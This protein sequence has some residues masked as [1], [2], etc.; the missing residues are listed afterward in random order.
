MKHI[1]S[2]PFSTVIRV[3]LFVFQVT[4]ALMSWVPPLE[5]AAVAVMHC[6]V[7]LAVVFSGRLTLVGLSVIAVTSLSVT[8]ALAVAVALPEDAVTVALPVAMPL[9]RPPLV[10]VTV[11]V[12][13]L[14]QH[15]VVPVQLV[16]PVRV[17]VFP[18]LSVPTALSCSVLF[19]L[20]DGLDGSI[21]TDVMVGFT[22]NPVQLTAST[23]VASAENT[24][25][26]RSLFLV[27][28]IAI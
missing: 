20:T 1:G 8:V 18:S 26:R 3:V 28:D 24:P 11:L 10:M 27:D 6:D 23:K 16:P 14:D 4:V 5:T 2:S 17:Y 19:T 21:V 15:T 7:P 22:K 13:E 9:S 25:V 12:S